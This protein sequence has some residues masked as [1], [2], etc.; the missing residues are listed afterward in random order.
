MKKYIISIFAL[1]AAMAVQAEILPKSLLVTMKDGNESIFK[2]ADTPVATFEGTDM[3]I[4]TGGG[5]ETVMIAMAEVNNMT[6]IDD[7]SA[8]EDL[9]DAAKATFIIGETQIKGAGLRASAK[10]ALYT[11]S[12]IM[13]AQTV[14]DDQG[15]FTVDI[16]AGATGTF[17]VRAGDRSF[18]FIK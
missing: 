16:P 12:G 18:K 3:K 7:K 13:V 8:V 1:L 17:I 11:V 6:I 5:A 15:S 10:V 14:T 2:F 4:T 9:K